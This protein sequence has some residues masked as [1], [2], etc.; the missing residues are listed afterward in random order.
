MKLK[1]ANIENRVHRIGGILKS[2]F[3]ND[4]VHTSSLCDKTQVDI[5]TIQRDLDMLKKSGFPIQEI[6]KGCYCLDKN[7]FK[8]FELFD[9]T[10]LALIFA[11]QNVISQLGPT[12]Q[13]AGASVFNRLFQV[14]SEPTCSPVFI[15]LDDPI[16]VESRLFKKVSKAI[17]E[18]KTVSFEYEVYAPYTVNL[19]P[20]KIAYYEGI[21]YLVGKETDNEQIKTFAFDKIKNIAVHNKRFRSIPADLEKSLNDSANVWFSGEKTTHVEIWVDKSCAQYF[22]RRKVF[23]TQKIKKEE[24]DGALV[25][26]FTVSNFNEIQYI[27]KKWLPHVKIL[28]PKEFKKEFAA[29][30]TDWLKWQNE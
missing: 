23:P 15:K 11:V 3:E 4:Q 8:N 2:F 6:K 21:W 18:K 22:K 7:L 12:F 13:K 9:E 1:R 19:E 24:K 30:I 14:M 29:E 16:F 25:V 28:N 10:E 27:L 26:S 17:N 5:R 20:Y